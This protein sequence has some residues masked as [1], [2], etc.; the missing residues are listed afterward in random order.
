M[1]INFCIYIFIFLLS[2]CAEPVSDA[3]LNAGFKSDLEYQEHLKKLAIKRDKEFLES[4]L[5]ASNPRQ[6]E[7]NEQYLQGLASLEKTKKRYISQGGTNYKLIHASSM[8][9]LNKERFSDVVDSRQ[10]KLR[11]AM[12]CVMDIEDPVTDS[13][14]YVNKMSKARYDLEVLMCRAKMIDGKYL[15]NDFYAEH[16]AA[17]KLANYD[18]EVQSLDQAKKIFIEFKNNIQEKNKIKED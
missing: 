6:F 10:E 11:E 1:R 5:Y 9:L 4:I 17:R 8:I 14:D 2:S 7:D 12:D 15:G 16:E 18:M 13:S 3:A